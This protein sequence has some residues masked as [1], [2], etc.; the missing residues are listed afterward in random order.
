MH[1]AIS[2]RSPIPPY[3]VTTFTVDAHDNLTE[4]VDPDGATTDVRLFD[5]LEPRGHQRDRP[6]RQYR[7][8]PLQQL[9][10][11]DQRDAL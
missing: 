7:D 2:V 10:P 6:R 11:V 4:I 9:R 5:A 3:R 1:L 8:G